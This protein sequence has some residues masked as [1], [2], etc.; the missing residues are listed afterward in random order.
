MTGG[1]GVVR[2]DPRT[3]RIA[4]R[5]RLSG[6]DLSAIAVGGGKL[7]LPDEREGVV[8]QIEPG[9]DPITRSINVG[10]GATTSPSVTAPPGPA[11][12][13]D[14]TVSGS[15]R[16]RIVVTSV[17]VGAVQALAAG[18][19][20]AWVSTA[21]GA[22]A[23]AMP[24]AACRELA[25]GGRK[26][27]VLIAS[28]LPLQGPSGA[29]P[30]GDRRRDPLRARAARLPA[31]RFS[32]GYQLVRR[33]DR[34]DRRLRGPPLRGERERVRARG[35]ARGG[36]RSVQLVLRADR[37][38]DP[39]PGAGRAAGMISPANTH[40]GPDPPVSEVGVVRRLPG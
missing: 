31:G 37:D 12:Y 34:A 2:I 32:V 11:N 16:P 39:Q 33:L 21:A 20:A 38:P 4:E 9:P 29:G 27:D 3:D 7:W 17:P 14:G 5:V 15:T 18:A 28:D 30:A 35:A 1:R 22:R 40:P 24:A 8:W 6:G 25:S 19:G 23:G 36:D 13:I 26:P 10:A